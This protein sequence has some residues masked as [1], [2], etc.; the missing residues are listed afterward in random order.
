MSRNE[1]ERVLFEGSI[2][3]LRISIAIK[4]ADEI[5]KILCKKFMRFMMMRAENFFVLRRKAVDVRL[6]ARGS[7]CACGFVALVSYS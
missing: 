3:S 6:H 2:N 7:L 5:E 4:Q 1:N